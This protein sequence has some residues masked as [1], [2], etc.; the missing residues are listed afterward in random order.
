MTNQMLAD[1]WTSDSI[2]TAIWAFVVVIGIIAA[3]VGYVRS[4]KW[5]AVEK[6]GWP[7]PKTTFDDNTMAMLKEVR[8]GTPQYRYTKTETP[9]EPK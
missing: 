8:K 7:K 5:A 4:K 2:E 1:C 6:Q 9:Q 3:N